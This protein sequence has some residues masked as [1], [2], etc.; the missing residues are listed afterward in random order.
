MRRS[1]RSGPAF[2]TTLGHSA[3]LDEEALAPAT[4]NRSRQRQN[5]PQP[6]HVFNTKPDAAAAKKR[7]LR[8][9]ELQ[10]IAAPVPSPESQVLRCA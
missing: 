2:R 1:V 10:A 4:D 6:A 9:V 5:A 8:K 3:R 7:S